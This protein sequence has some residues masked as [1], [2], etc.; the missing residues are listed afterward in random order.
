[1]TPGF[2][3]STLRSSQLYIALYQKP[4]YVVKNAFPTF[5]IV[6]GRQLQLKSLYVVPWPATILQSRSANLRVY[7]IEGIFLPQIHRIYITK[8]QKKLIWPLCG[9]T[10]K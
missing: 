2:K 10:Q 9:F 6:V 1:M 3:D 5:K 4:M 8:K 7:I